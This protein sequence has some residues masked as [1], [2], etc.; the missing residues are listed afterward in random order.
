[1]AASIDHEAIALRLV[2]RMLAKRIA[3]LEGATEWRASMD[4][5]HRVTT[6]EIDRTDIPG[7][8]EVAAMRERVEIKRLVGIILGPKPGRNRR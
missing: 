6:N 7:L 5:L 2:V 8:D 1:M 4:N 3:M